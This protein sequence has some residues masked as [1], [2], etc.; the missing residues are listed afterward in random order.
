MEYYKLG[1]NES[2]LFKCDC[3]DELKIILTNLNFV[4]ININKRLLH[5]DEAV[6]EVIPKEDVKFYNEK[7]QIKQQG[8]LVEM[9]FKHQEK[10]V[11]FNSRMDAYKFVHTANELL[12]G[13]TMAERGAAKVKDGITLV[14]DTLG[15]STVDTVKGVIENGVIGSIFGGIGKKKSRTKKI[16]GKSDTIKESAKKSLQSGVDALQQKNAEKNINEYNK[17]LDSLK[18]LKDLVDKGVLTEEEFEKKKKEILG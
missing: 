4:F 16:S 6:V 1:E 14:D 18:K 7:P 12:T 11:T 9:Y 17:Q 15:F 3:S 8:S 13:H 5:S 2:P 10:S